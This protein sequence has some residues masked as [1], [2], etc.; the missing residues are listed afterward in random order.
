MTFP[1]TRQ[2]ARFDPLTLSI[3]LNDIRADV[4]AKDLEEKKYSNL[5]QPLSTIY[6]E[7]THWADT[8]GT[9]WGNTYLQR[10][11]DAMEVLPRVNELGSEGDFH[12]FMT[13]RSADR[14]LSYPSYYR[15]QF[16]SAAPHSHSKRWRIEFSTGLEFD[17]DGRQNERKPVIFVKFSDNESGSPIVRQPLCIA[18]LLETTAVWS[19][20]AT[21]MQLI[22]KISSDEKMLEL[23]FFKREFLA[24]L[25]SEHLTLYTAP[26]HLLAHF[27]RITDTSLAYHLGALVS[28][29]CLNL[30]GSHFKALIPPLRMDAWR[31]RFT[32]FKRMES[33]PF[34]FFCICA[35][36]PT[37]TADSSPDVWLEAALAST[38]LP[39]SAEIFRHAAN[40][41]SKDERVCGDKSLADQQ[42]YLRGVGARWLSD[43]SRRVEPSISLHQVSEKGLSTPPMFDANERPFLMLGSDFDLNLFDPSHLFE[44]GSR[45]H[46]HI[47]KFSEACR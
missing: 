1:N 13:V 43:R 35:N 16:S 19:E 23:A 3:V 36:A 33:I 28:F 38:G 30:V 37:W 14:H 6:H 11:F 39:P 24:R 10:I 25:Y 42:I 47:L 4:L 40:I 44:I 7:I 17:F 26:V 29:I 46:T 21:Q 20:M 5:R 34:A 27:A 8:V 18:A 31:E 41:L 22:E 15:L 45:L 32:S 2:V 12:R 9:L